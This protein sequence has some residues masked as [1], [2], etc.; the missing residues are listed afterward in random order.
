MTTVRS[1]T[2]RSD[3]SSA[4]RV[5][6]LG[7]LVL[8]VFGAIS[9]C[10]GASTGGSGPLLLSTAASSGGASGPTVTFTKDVAPIIQQNCQ[11]CHQK[12]SIGPMPLTTYDEVKPF[13]QL[14]R[15]R[16]ST[17]T[18]PPWHMDPSVGI[19]EFKN[20]IS[21]SD[22]EIRTIVAWAEQGAPQGNPADMPPP[23]SF[24]TAAD[25]RLEGQFGA[26]DLVLKS[27]PYT[28]PA[29]GQDAWWRPTTPTGLTEPRWL[30]AVEVR[31]SYPKGRGVTHHTLVTL[32]QQEDGITGLASTA[33][34]D[35]NSPGLLTEW[36]IG[37]VGEVYPAGTGKLLLPGSRI[38]WEV[39]Y[40]PNGGE[41][42]NDQVEI[43]MWFYP[44]GQEP[45]YR[46]I[47]NFWSVA[48]S[49]RLEI[50][51]HSTAVHQNTI[52]LP[53]PAR[54]ESFQ[55]HMH[56]RGKAMSMEAIY[57][58]GR[59]ELLNMV[60]NFQWRWHINYLY[61]DDAAP[62]L[63]K[64]TVLLFTAWHDNT[65][66]NPENPDPDQYIT[67][68]DRTVD[69]MAHAWVGVTYLEEADFERMVAERAEKT[70]TRASEIPDDHDHPQP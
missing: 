10:V 67:W 12:G 9:S 33:A 8:A 29:H 63:P 49:N 24:P 68:G 16:V 57:P 20:D 60:S 13:A 54:I 65:D 37:K 22:E 50:A 61:G 55:P 18:M 59:R 41:V 47:L 45:K 2:E 23:V 31:P 56:M 27:D 7:V 25:W 21:L 42:Q 52:V 19:K 1:Q 43:A 11:I 38:R 3:R 44:V 39:H 69:E 14:I 36:A 51:P 53:A 46:T 30:R 70:K 6:P 4:R 62:L 26:P 40:W 58:D 48:A 28:V 64:G 17:R 35:V 32:L 15:Q 66:N 5:A 34:D